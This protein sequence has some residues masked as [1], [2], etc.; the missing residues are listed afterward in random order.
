MTETHGDNAREIPAQLLTASIRRPLPPRSGYFSVG[1]ARRPDGTVISVD[2]DSLL[3]NGR[4]WLAA[5]GEMHYSRYPQDEWRDELLKMKAGGISIVASYVFWIHHE[6]E[7]GR[8]DWSG[9]RDL[10]AFV[11]TCAEVRLPAVIRCG[12][13]CHGEVRNGGLP[14]WVQHAGWKLRS[15]D[16]HFLDKVRIL[17]SQ[18][19][20]QLKG[21][22]WKDGGPVIAVQVDNEYRGPAEYLLALKRIARDVGLDVPFYTRTGWPELTTPMPLGEILPLYGCYADGFWDRSIDEMPGDGWSKFLFSH[23]RNDTEI[24][25]DQL[26]KRRTEDSDDTARYPHLTCEIGGGMMTSYHRRILVYPANIESVSMIQLGNGSAMPGYYMYHGGTNPEGKLSTLQESQATGY[27]NDLPVKTY[28]FQAPLGEYGQVRPHYHMLR[29]MHL[30]LQDF[31]SQL[32]AMKP[33]FPDR[34]PTDVND[35]STL[36]WIVRSDGRSGLVFVNNYRRIRPLPEKPGVH[37]EVRLPDGPLRFPSKP[38]IVPAN[39]RFFWPFNLDLGGITLKYATAQPVCFIDNGNIRTVFFAETAGI[40]AEFAF[41][42][43]KGDILH[44]LENKGVRNLYFAQP[45]INGV[46]P[47]LSVTPSHEAFASISAADGRTVRLVLLDDESS[48]AL[49]KGEWAG[50]E[51]VFLSRASLIIDGNTI[52]LSASSLSDHSISVFPAPDKVTAG[53]GKL[54]TASDGIFTRFVPL[55]PRPVKYTVTAELIREAGP[56]REIRMGKIKQPVAE[57]PNDA[58]FEKAALW[59]ITLPKDMDLA[60]DPILRITY[61]GDVARILLDGGLLNDNFYNGAS[62]EIGLKRH[63]PDILEKELTLA[64]LPLRKDAPIYLQKEAQ[65]DF[66]GKDSIAELHKIEIIPR[67]PA[68]LD[69]S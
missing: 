9:Q 19:S 36:R 42:S 4:R 17:Y 27:W 52:H 5:M 28:D 45:G 30:F 59:R 20:S 6:E 67:Y 65:P 10:R 39:A 43:D 15:E 33:F 68:R 29:R 16:P 62:F 53:T 64:I 8:W 63:A 47:H 31:G 48:L 1:S 22:L 35:E 50:K 11:Q 55:P 66:R 12:P 49:W 13:W 58:D 44:S 18:I 32:A 51:R 46:G 24:A 23:T 7:E 34:A 38:M 69:A 40:P 41:A 56:A 3:L 60:Y 25:T 57:A 26:G 37:F 54:T 2:S 14:D 21:L 61:V